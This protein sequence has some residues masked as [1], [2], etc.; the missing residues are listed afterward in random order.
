M[1]SNVVAKWIHI[2]K[3]FC[4]SVEQMSYGSEPGL[5]LLEDPAASALV[6]V[7]RYCDTV[8]LTS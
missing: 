1:V 5:E 3:A 6:K 4:L 8:T 2:R 7:R